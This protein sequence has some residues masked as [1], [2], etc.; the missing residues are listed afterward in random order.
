MHDGLRFCALT[1]L[2]TPGLEIPVI[3]GNLGD[4]AAL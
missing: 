4:F 1:R 3:A 2:A